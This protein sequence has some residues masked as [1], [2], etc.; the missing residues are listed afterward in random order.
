MCE[1]LNVRSLSPFE[2]RDFVVE[3]VGS[4]LEFLVEGLKVLDV[5]GL[6][7]KLS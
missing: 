2:S 3:Q 6:C 1:F 7:P 5:C 4:C